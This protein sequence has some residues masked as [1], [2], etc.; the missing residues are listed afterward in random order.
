MP[1]SDINI[2][3]MSKIYNVRGENI[4]RQRREMVSAGAG[5]GGCSLAGGLTE[6]ALFEQEPEGG[7][8]PEVEPSRPLGGLAGVQRSLESIEEAGDEVRLGNLLILT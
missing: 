3:C 7:G 5:S 6:D 1:E 8:C 2:K 4:V